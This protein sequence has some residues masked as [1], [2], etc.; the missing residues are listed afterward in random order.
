VSDFE[1]EYVE[2]QQEPVY[3]QLDAAT[4]A[5]I[6]QH[7][8]TQG[9]IQAMN[10]AKNDDTVRK[11]NE[12]VQALN[13]RFA[14]KYTDWDAVAPHIAPMLASGE[15]IR[16]DQTDAEWDLQ[17]DRL[18]RVVGDDLNEKTRKKDAATARERWA[19]IQNAGPGSYHDLM[20]RGSE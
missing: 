14:E 5:E 16:A 18:A 3:S 9:A 15:F 2:Q 6:G 13:T 12:R 11:Y 8:A 10:A 19:K 1:P 7:Y 17:I 20:R 4:I